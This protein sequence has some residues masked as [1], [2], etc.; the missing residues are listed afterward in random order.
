MLKWLKRMGIFLLAVIA[1]LAVWICIGSIDQSSFDDRGLLS[2]LKPVPD[3]ENGFLDIAYLNNDDF[4]FNGGDKKISLRDLASGEVWDSSAARALLK[5]NQKVIDDIRKA[6]RK[7]AFQMP[8]IHGDPLKIANYQYF[9]KANYLLIIESRLH[10]QDMDFDRAIDSA[11][12]AIKFSQNIKSDGSGYLISY[13]VGSSMQGFSVS[14][15]HQMVSSYQLSLLQYHEIQL[16]LDN[17]PDYQKDNF[18]RVIAGEFRFGK[19]SMEN[20]LENSMPEKMDYLNTMLEVR[21]YNDRVASFKELS[22]LFLT[23][24]FPDFYMHPNRVASKNAI[25]M[26]E[27][28]SYVNEYCNAIPVLEKDTESYD[29]MDYVSDP[30]WNDF[31]TPNAL[32]KQLLEVS[33]SYTEYFA[34]RCLAYVYLDAVKTAVAT[35]NY[36][37]QHDGKLPERLEELVPDYLD[38]LPIDYFDGKPLRY[39]R[40]NQRVYSVGNDYQDDGGSAE[41]IYQGRC[42]EEDACYNSPTVPL[43]APLP[44]QS[45]SGKES[46]EQ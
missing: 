35:K 14:W 46:C 34:R 33:Y 42:T 9:V 32:G 19:E 39:S 17:I 24:M 23:S 26:A 29:H 41:G 21:N 11:K 6:N 40:E 22:Y 15:I 38:R 16:L 2:E 36:Q 27:M 7:P 31:F 45:V 30:P 10:V 4:E 20:T 12:D 28:A 3:A 13:M 8:D 44:Q 18:N 25:Y 5:D 43:S 1:L 37:T